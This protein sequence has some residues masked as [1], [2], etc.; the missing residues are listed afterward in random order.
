M[1][2]INANNQQDT[3]N[4]MLNDPQYPDTN[5]ILMYWGPVAQ[6][7][8]TYANLRVPT[9]PILDTV[10]STN[11]NYFCPRIYKQ[12]LLQWNFARTD[13]T[14]VKV[15]LWRVSPSWG[16]S[17][18]LTNGIWSFDY[19]IAV[20]W[21]K[22]WQVIWEH[23][24]APLCFLSTNVDITFASAGDMMQLD[25]FLLHTDWTTTSIATLNNPIKTSWYWSLHTSTEWIVYWGTYTIFTFKYDWTWQT[26]QDNDILCCKVHF[27][28]MKQKWYGA[29]NY[30][31]YYWSTNNNCISNIDWFRPFQV[32]IRDS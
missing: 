25:F 5:Q 13:F 3:T 9:L 6:G 26:A 4:F 29:G 24:M 11:I 2:V 32:S 16:S 8:G 12:W 27:W 20:N 10:G 1:L 19:I 22:S 17:G 14:N 30:W 15:D 7:N 23:I 31:I 18:T 21:L 28:A